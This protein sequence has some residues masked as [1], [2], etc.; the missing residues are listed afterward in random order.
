[1]TQQ[2]I[3]QII[4][5]QLAQVASEDSMTDNCKIVVCSER[6]FIDDFA[7]RAD[8][9][10]RAMRDGNVDIDNPIDM[11]FRNTIFFVIKVGDGTSNF[12]IIQNSFSIQA[13]SEENSFDAAKRILELFVDK[14]NFTYTEEGMIEAFHRPSIS[15]SGEQ[16]YSGF[17]ALI[18]L[19]GDL[20]FPAKG[21]LFIRNIEASEDGVHYFN[22]PFINVTF[23]PS[24]QPDSASFAGYNGANMSLNKASTQVVSIST[25]LWDNGDNNSDLDAFSAHVVDAVD[26]M[27]RKFKLK[28]NTSKSGTTICDDWFILMSATYG[29]SLGEVSVWNLTFA[30]A[31][32]FEEG[33]R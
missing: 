11:P 18:N 28:L 6:M 15:S 20:K 33:E 22:L 7:P 10:E 2:E 13:L 21:V 26:D 30:R 31:K 17:R 14:Y 25:Y 12:A 3:T 1:M 24:C 29:Q 9:Y 8:E 27:N 32:Q 23:S 5:N 4:A 16:M 19:S